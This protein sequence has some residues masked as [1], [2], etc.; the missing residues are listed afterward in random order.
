MSRFAFYGRVS[1]EDQQDPESSRQWQLPRSSSAHR[2]GTAGDR[3][4]VL[5]H[6]HEPVVAME[7]PSRGGSRCSR[8]FPSRPRLRRPSS[9]A[10]R[11]GR[12][13]ATSS[14][15]RSRCSRTTASSFGCPRSAARIDPGSDAHDLVMIAVRR[16]VEGRAEADQ[17]P[18]PVRHGAPGRNA[19]AGSSAAGRRTAT[20]SPTPARTRTRGRPATGSG[21]TGSS[22]TRRRRR[23]SSGSSTSTSPAAAAT[24]SPRA[25]RPTAIP[26]PS[27]ARPGP[28]PAP[29]T[30]W[31]GGSRRPGDPQNPRYT[32]LRGVEQAARGTR[33]SSTSRTSRSAT[34]RCMR[35]NGA[36]AVGLVERARPTRRSSI[37]R[38]SEGRRTIVA[39]ADGPQA[40]AADRSPRPTCSAACSTAG[41]AGAR[42]RA[43]GTTTRPTTAASTGVRVRGIAELDHPQDRLPPRG[44]DRSPTSTMARHAVRPGATSTRPARRSLGAHRARA[45]PTGRAGDLAGRARRLRPQAR[46][47][48]AASRPAPTPPSSPAGS[49]RCGRAQRGAEPPRRSRR[50]RSRRHIDTADEI[51]AHVEHLGGLIGAAAK[52]TTRSSDSRVLQGAGRRAPTTPTDARSS[53]RQRAGSVYSGFVSEGGLEPPRPCGHQPLKLARL[54]IPPLRRDRPERPRRATTLAAARRRREPLPGVPRPA[55]AA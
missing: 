2:A 38:P 31:P 43:A 35:W 4:G 46:P 39:G 47:L 5:R 23:S 45:T 42:C 37:R 14:G 50:E 36:G 30:G 33:C 29:R 21:S 52:V 3:R 26:S 13:T 11:S 19:R 49:R 40:T 6:R 8:R 16:H 20:G 18:R 17:D 24:P 44:R 22:P 54:P 15:S 12:S 32:G 51:A 25:S 7:A 28:Q 53:R 1:T 48:P 34:R 27:G 9:S 10:S 55:D 41:S